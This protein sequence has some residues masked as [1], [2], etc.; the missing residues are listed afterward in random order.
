MIKRVVLGLLG[1]VLAALLLVGV[2]VVLAL[3]RDYLP[4]K[5]ALR[6]G[7]VY[8]EVDAPPLTFVVM[9]DSTAAGVGAGSADNAYPTLLA[10]RIAQ[11]RYRVRLVGVGVSGE[12]LDDEI[13][14]Q[15]LEA[16]AEKPDLVFV[17]LGANDVTHLTRLR[18]VEENMR[19]VIVSLEDAD[20]EVV[21]AGPP[22]MRSPVFYEP[23][24]T[25]VGWRGRAVQETIEE[26][27]R[28]EG[29]PVVPL[30]DETRDFF[31]AD[32]DRYYSEDDFHPSAAGYALWADVIFP[33]VE[34][35]LPQRYPRATRLRSPS[36][37]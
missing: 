8:G 11:E 4:T 5:P 29:V 7:G 33:Y 35:V 24:R 9:G 6:I 16:T 25:I 20:A 26:V 37:P 32:P 36:R 22:D 21:V 3:R 10:R 12:R 15:I 23:L 14:D 19:S 30:A 13:Y 2:E 27:A 28:E 1:L 18:T 17:C 34:E 31:A